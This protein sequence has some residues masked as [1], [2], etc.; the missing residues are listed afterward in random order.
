MADILGPRTR[1][2]A[3]LHGIEY[4][5]DNMAAVSFEIFSG[6]HRLDDKTR[7]RALVCLGVA[8][9]GR[10]RTDYERIVADAARRLARDLSQMATEIVET[11]GPEQ[12]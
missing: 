2:N 4:T 9:N 7:F 3:R 10:G 12:A 1:L 8:L 5:S 6:G 11:H